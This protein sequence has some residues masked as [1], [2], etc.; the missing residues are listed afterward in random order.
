MEYCTTDL[1]FSLLQEL[2]CSGRSP[3]FLSTVSRLV[4]SRDSGYANIRRIVSEVPKRDMPPLLSIVTWIHLAVLIITTSF[5]WTN[6]IPYVEKVNSRTA[7]K[8]KYAL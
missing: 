7:K 6:A 2:A 3:L 5:F 1:N 4:S 8:C